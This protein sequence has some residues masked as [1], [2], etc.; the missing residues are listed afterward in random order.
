MKDALCKVAVSFLNQ[1]RRGASCGISGIVAVGKSKSSSSSVAARSKYSVPEL[2]ALLVTV[3]V[4]KASTPTAVHAP[5]AT[6]PTAVN[7]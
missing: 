6:T 5:N 7:V 3:A 2:P 4:P 1:V